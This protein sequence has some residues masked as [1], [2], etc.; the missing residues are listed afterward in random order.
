MNVSYYETLIAGAVSGSAFTYLWWMLTRNRRVVPEVR[1]L[2]GEIDKR[3]E[4]LQRVNALT[5]IQKKIAGFDRLITPDRA[6]ELYEWAERV[7]RSDRKVDPVTLT[8]Q[9]IICEK[10]LGLTRLDALH[11]IKQA[12]LEDDIRSHLPLKTPEGTTNSK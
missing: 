1:R 7:R 5:P 10:L 6:L 8:A 12:K 4:D 3:F 11:A 2:L 9:A